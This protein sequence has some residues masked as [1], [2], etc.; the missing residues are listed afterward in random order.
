MKKIIYWRIKIKINQ[1][2]LNTNNI[3][4]YGLLCFTCLRLFVRNAIKP[5]LI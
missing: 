5:C 4:I 3:I 1:K 2:T